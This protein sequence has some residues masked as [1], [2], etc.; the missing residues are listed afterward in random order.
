MSNQEINYNSSFNGIT[1]DE[2]LEYILTVPELKNNLY[3]QWRL[4]KI[5]KLQ[6][7]INIL[8]SDIEILKETINHI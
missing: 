3:V 8:H 1:D 4:N 2:L 5:S 6:E 7:T